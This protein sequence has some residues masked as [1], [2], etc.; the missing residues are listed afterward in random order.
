MERIPFLGF[1]LSP[2]IKRGLLVLSKCDTK[3]FRPVLEIVAL[4]LRG[5]IPH[6]EHFT[7]ASSKTGVPLVELEAL[8]TGTLAILKA[9]ICSH[10]ASEHFKVDLAELKIADQHIADMDAVLRKRCPFLC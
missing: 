10:T 5:D 6:A 7:T 4:A 2:E 8:F 3:Q 1:T 9:A